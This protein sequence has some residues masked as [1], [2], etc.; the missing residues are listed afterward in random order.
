VSDSI[1]AIGDVFLQLISSQSQEQTYQRTIIADSAQAEYGGS[2]WNVAWNLEQL[3]W[4]TRMLAQHGPDAVGR[5]PPLPISGRDALEPS[6]CKHTRTDQLLVFPNIAMPAIYLF[7]RLSQH[8]LDA[9]FTD[10]GGHAAIV[11]AGSRHPE[12]RRRTFDTLFSHPG[13][14][15]VFSPSYTVYEYGTQELAAFLAH[16][17]IAIVN[18]REAAFLKDV[19]SAD[20]AAVMARANIAGIVMRDV[21]GAAIYPAGKSSF[22]LPSTS[23]VRGDVIGAGDAFLSGFV[24]GFLRSRDVN[25]AARAGI[26]VSAQTALSGRVCAVLDIARARTAAGL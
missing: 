5:L 23:G 22:H 6:W 24:D 9:M 11:F 14:L 3:G 21:D 19:F 1:V 13:P 10:A 4:N 8:E 15:R 12:L 16:A 26:E 2:A 18:R 17:D 20:E 7:G 25:A